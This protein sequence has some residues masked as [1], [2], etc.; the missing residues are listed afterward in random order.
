MQNSNIGFKTWG[1]GERIHLAPYEKF[2]RGGRSPCPPQD[3]R[4]CNLQNSR[5]DLIRLAAVLDMCSIWLLLLVTF[6]LCNFYA[7]MTLCMTLNCALHYSNYVRST[8]KMGQGEWPLLS[9]QRWY[10]A[11]WEL[12]GYSIL[13]FLHRT[14]FSAILA[15]FC[16]NLVV[17]ATLL[18]PL[19]F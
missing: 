9:G 11:N 16:Q 10:V 7:T 1:G 14:E 8:F 5:C 2:W 4:L 12:V 18:A 6:I 3:R 13:Y 15:Y 19:K 17:I